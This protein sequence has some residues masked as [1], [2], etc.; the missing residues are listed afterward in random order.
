ME[1]PSHPSP[2]PSWKH[3]C[4]AQRCIVSCPSGT[5]SLSLLPRGSDYHQQ[6]PWCGQAGVQPL[7]WLPPFVPLPLAETC[8]KCTL[9]ATRGPA[10]VRCRARQH[11]SKRLGEGIS[12]IVYQRA[13]FPSVNQIISVVGVCVDL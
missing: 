11:S 8:S 10:L 7:G 3:Q 1:T 12:E 13:Y 2:R 6:R 5:V 4:L 9:P